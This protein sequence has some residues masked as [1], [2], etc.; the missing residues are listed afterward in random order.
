MKIM[1]ENIKLIEKM[2]M[3]IAWQGPC[4]MCK[5]QTQMTNRNVVVSYILEYMA[6]HITHCN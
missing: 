3:I 2:V 1:H 4:I 6:S 5:L